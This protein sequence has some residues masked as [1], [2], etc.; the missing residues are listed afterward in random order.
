M[1]SKIDSPSFVSG[2]AHVRGPLIASG[3]PTISR[4]EGIAVLVTGEPGR[5]YDMFVNSQR[6]G[7]G[8]TMGDSGSY[9]APIVLA[10]GL[11]QVC[12]ATRK[13]PIDSQPRESVHCLSVA[14]IPSSDGS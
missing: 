3:L 6:V 11:N 7:D 8:I 1:A 2:V 10:V 9:G 14:Y 4:R 5:G 12:I 13:N